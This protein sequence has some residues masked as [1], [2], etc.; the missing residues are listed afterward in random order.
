MTIAL[1]ISAPAFA[2]EGDDLFAAGKYEQAAG[3]FNQYIKDNPNNSK[4]TPHALMGL[5]ESLEK[6][7]DIINTGAERQCFRSGGQ[8]G[9]PCMNAYAEKL[10]SVYGA[11]SFQ[12][13]ENMV[14][15]RYT[16]AHYR[17]VADE[18][19]KSDYAAEAAYRLLGKELVGH[20]DQVLPKIKA[21][22]SKYPSG[23]WGRMGKLLWGR[24][25]EDIWWIHRK[26]SWV[27]YNWQIS[28]EELIVKSEPYRQEALRTFE[29]LMKKDGST[30]EGKAAKRE[31]DLLKSYKDDGAIYGIINESNV[32]G[33][34][35]YGK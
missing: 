10:N 18:F 19:P 17:R 31:Y 5:A 33:S 21:Y 26:W 34:G 16:G 1:L 14:F 29:E 25:N 35:A 23:K 9:T 32:E 4:E 22:M 11:G 13:M 2:N 27:L 3:W 12:Y 8:K 30:D 15:I 28:Q 7:S 24:I 20:P 6:M